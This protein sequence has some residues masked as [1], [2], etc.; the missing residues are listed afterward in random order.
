[1]TEIIKRYDLVIPIGRFCHCAGLL[2]NYGLKLF[3]GPWDWSGTGREEGIYKRLEALTQGF[4]GWFEREDFVPLDGENAL[5]L[6]DYTEPS[7]PRPEYIFQKRMLAPS[8]DIWFYNK[9]TFT[10]YGHDFKIN[11]A[12][13]KQFDLIKTRYLRRFRRIEKFIQSANS[14]LLVYMCHIADQKR[15][16]HLDENMVLK[17]MSDLRCKYKDKVI[18]LYMFE[19]NHDIVDDDWKRYILD[20]GIIRYESNHDNVWDTNDKNPKHQANEFMMPKSVCNILEQITLTDKFKM[21]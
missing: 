3:D 11:I 16:L 20:V 10:Y 13:D 7:A 19:H 9:K 17:Y 6:T 1:M 5:Y 4:D 2:N 12:F 15:D 21:I 8:P 14:I 18:D